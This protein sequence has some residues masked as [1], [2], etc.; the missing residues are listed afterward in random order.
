MAHGHG[1]ARWRLV[2]DTLWLGNDYEPYYHPI[3]N[4]R[5]QEVSQ[6]HLG[7]WDTL[8]VQRRR[9]YP[10]PDSVYWAPAFRDTTRT[11]APITEEKPWQ[12]GTWVYKVAV[13]ERRDSLIQKISLVRIESLSRATASV[14]VKAVLTRDPRV[15]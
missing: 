3:I 4:T 5:Q 15:K 12:C 6:N 7:V 1:G 9:P 8:L 10:V 14:A 13:L 2:G 11:C